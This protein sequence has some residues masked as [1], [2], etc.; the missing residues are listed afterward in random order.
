MEEQRFDWR[1]IAR[2]TSIIIGITALFGLITPVVGAFIDGNGPIDTGV[3]SGSQI[4]RWLFWTI[5][6]ALTIWQ[7]SWMIRH[8]GDRII[9]DMLVTSILAAIVLIIVKFIVWLIFEPTGPDGQQ[10]LPITAIDAAGG[11]MLVVMAL[12]GARINRY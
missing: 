10:L 8:V 6:W 3:V 2:A 4:Y 5:A 7:A 1:A 12:V 9:D 11:L